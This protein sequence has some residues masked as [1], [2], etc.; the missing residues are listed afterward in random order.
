MTAD[1][2]F[3]TITD[4]DNQRQQAMLSGDIDTVEQYIG[5][6]LRYVHASG[7]DEDRTVY[8]ERLRNGYYRYQHLE[9]SRRDY[10]HF[11]D[12][13]IVNGD[14]RIHVIVDGRERDFTGRFLQIWAL[15]DGDW[16]MVAWQTTR[17]PTD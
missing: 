3:T 17:L 11:G 4:R 6:T 2:I 9:T 5:S 13:V 15:Q 14:L 12:T 10:R 1:A 8:L 16:K 7:T